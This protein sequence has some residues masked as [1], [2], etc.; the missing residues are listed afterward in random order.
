MRMG[1]KRE[2]REIRRKVF[3]RKVGRVM[4]RRERWR[5]I[6][7]SKY[8]KWYKMIKEEGISEYLKKGWGRVDGQ[9]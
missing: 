9:E 8:N 7:D 5:R 3:K 1:G 6:I 4:N 2:N